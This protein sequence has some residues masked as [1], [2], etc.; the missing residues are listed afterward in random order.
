MLAI[1]V[2]SD[3]RL[4]LTTRRRC[5]VGPGIAMLAAA[6][7]A[8]LC[9]CAPTLSAKP[10]TPEAAPP[11]RPIV[12][13]PPAAPP[14]QEAP[15]LTIAERAARLDA[16]LQAESQNPSSGT[17]ADYES[18]YPRFMPAPKA[19]ADGSLQSFALIDTGPYLA[20]FK[21]H[22]LT[23]TNDSGRRLSIYKAYLWTGVDRGAIA[24]VHLEA[25][26]VS[27]N[28]YIGILQWD[29]YAD[30]TVPQHGQQFDYS[31]P[32]VL[33][34]GDAIAILH[35]ANGFSPGWHAHH[36]VILWVK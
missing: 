17:S 9:S 16:R 24:D 3:K 10:P 30:P 6:S 11:P 14:R 26:R 8:L 27:D 1:A 4:R 23:W 19:R 18:G 32:M 20:N 28:S 33:D 2:Q 22:R 13:A 15:Q 12:E 31:T 7:L 29:H 21:V 25:R 34:P 35:F 36:A 5:G